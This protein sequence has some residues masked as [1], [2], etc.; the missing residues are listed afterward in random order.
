LRSNKKLYKQILSDLPGLEFREITDPE[1]ECATILTV[2]LPDA[3]V[4]RKIAAE[5]GTKVI[6]EAGWHV[7][8][9]MEQILEQR[10]ITEERCPFTCPFY[11][12]KG[13]NMTYRKGML[14]LTDALLARS[15]NISIGVSD[16]GL[17]S[18]YGVTMRDGPEQV[19]E[20]ANLFRKV[21]LK[22]LR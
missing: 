15:L 19:H 17:S 13:G 16:P 10:T 1:G 20:R 11:V 8:A 6:A 4:A 18:A 3:E 12:Q 9:N 21:A 22:Y 2:I 14:P 5:L 7:Y